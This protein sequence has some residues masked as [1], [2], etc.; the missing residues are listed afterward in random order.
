MKEEPTTG[1]VLRRDD[2]HTLLGYDDGARCLLTNTEYAKVKG[3]LERREKLR[4]V[5]ERIN[6]WT[7]IWRENDPTKKDGLSPDVLVR[8]KCGRVEMHNL[9]T[10]RY[11]RSEAC[12]DCGSKWREER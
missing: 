1:R 2:T 9:T 8:C 11:G 3:I 12:N 5:G 7:I 4:A 10:L 6:S